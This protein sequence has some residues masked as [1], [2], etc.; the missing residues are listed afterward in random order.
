MRSTPLRLMIYFNRLICILSSALFL[1]GCGSG[2]SG[3]PSP[4]GSF[5]SLRFNAQSDKSAYIAGEMASIVLTASNS[6]AVPVTI[7]SGTPSF[8]L[9]YPM[10]ISVDI[11]KGSKIVRQHYPGPGIGDFITIQPASNQVGKLLWDL[12][13]DDNVNVPSGTYTAIAF[14]SAYQID[15]VAFSA[16]NYELAAPPISIK[17]N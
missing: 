1:M 2:S 3:P 16:I 5:R 12:K 10:A 8:S 15:G 14:V 17:V 11:Y 9:Q 7:A 4:S 13:D 6:G